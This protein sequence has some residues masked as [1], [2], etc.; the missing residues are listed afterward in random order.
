MSGANLRNGLLRTGVAL[1]AA[2]AGYK[3]NQHE[4]AR[5]I[6]SVP[7]TDELPH[8]RLGIL[9]ST[10]GTSSQATMDAIKNRTLNASIAAII[11]NNPEA[12]ILQRAVEN[13]FDGIYISEKHD[14]GK[15]KTRVEYHDQISRIFRDN[16]VELILCVGYNKII[17][18]SF[19]DD[20]EGAMLN[21]HPSLLPKHKGLFDLAVHKAVLD[22]GD[23][24]SGATIHF[25]TKE[26]DAGPIVAQMECD[27]LPSDTPETLKAR[28]QALEGPGFVRAIEVYAARKR[29]LMHQQ[30]VAAAVEDAKDTI[31]MRNCTFG[32]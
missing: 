15:K 32:M 17:P 4:L 19:V 12:F 10:R 14:N 25:I 21:V 18:D 2:Y 23:K 29:D 8:I 6:R 16:G 30:A 11:S 31:V 5:T 28:V 1:T 27:V 22:A 3:I 26:V 13:G 20:W 24:K 9:G 7:K